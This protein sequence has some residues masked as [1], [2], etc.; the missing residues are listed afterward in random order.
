VTPC[1]TCHTQPLIA[2]ADVPHRC[3]RK[4]QREH[5]FN[6]LFSSTLFVGKDNKLSTHMPG[7]PPPHPYPPSCLV[8]REPWRQQHLQRLMSLVRTRLG[9]P[10][11]SPIIP[12]VVG[13]EAA[14]L[15]LSRQ[16]LS[17]GFHV[18]AIRPPTVPAGTCRLRLSLSAGHSVDQVNALLDA[19]QAALSSMQGVKLQSLPHLVL[20]QQQQEQ[21]QQEQQ[22]LPNTQRQQEEQLAGHQQPLLSL[23]QSP[24]QPQHVGHGSNLARTVTSNITSVLQQSKL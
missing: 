3:A 10:V 9:V 8:S 11:V 4:S 2:L 23:R 5:S 24:T 18:P 1:R 22:A 7:P 19:L 20:Q 17:A 16:L 13:S 14:A 21:Q 15:Q 12:L 6:L